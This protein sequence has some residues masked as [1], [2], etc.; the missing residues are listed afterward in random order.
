MTK[1]ILLSFDV[2]EF[3]IPEEYGQK[4]GEKEKFEISLQGLNK[5][6]QILDGLNIHATFFVTSIFAIKNPELIKEM[7]IKHEIASHG[8]SHSHISKEDLKKSKEDLE[9]I[10]CKK[11]Y[12]FRA[13]RLKKFKEHE[14]LNAGY[15]YDSSLNPT[16]IP[17]RY[18]NFFKKRTIHYSNNLF[19]IPIS[20]TPLFRFPI[21]WL[22][23]KNFPLFLIKMNSKKILKKDSYLNIFFHPWEFTDISQFKIPF[24]VKKDSKSKLL[25]KLKKYLVWLKENGEFIS[26]KEFKD[27]KSIR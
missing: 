9:K 3:D 1:K 11:V 4:V 22:T 18:N 16:F 27:I 19:K 25:R 13:P 12:G 15:K 14:I 21:F 10:I 20:V 8:F 17:G 26:L 2:E 23:F 7:S 6:L 5:I 24:Y